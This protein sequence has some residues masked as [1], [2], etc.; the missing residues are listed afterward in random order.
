MLLVTRA[1]AEANDLCGTCG[2]GS[3]KTREVQDKGGAHEM[4]FTSPFVVEATS[5]GE[6]IEG[7]APCLKHMT[8]SDTKIHFCS[9][10]NSLRSAVTVFAREPIARQ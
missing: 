7:A 3:M 9:V 10:T 6:S 8:D 5:C 2:G 1:Q 4:F